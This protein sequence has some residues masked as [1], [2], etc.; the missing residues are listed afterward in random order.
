MAEEVVVDNTAAKVQDTPN[1]AIEAQAKRMGWKPDFPGEGKLSA[2]DFVKKHDETPA[3]LKAELNRA[4]ARIAA[5]E[6]ESRE[7]VKAAKEFQK[8]AEANAQ[9]EW[10][11]KY[12]TL[13]AAQAK[14]VREGDEEAFSAAASDIDTH[15][16]A[17]PT[18]KADAP[19]SQVI[20]PIVTTWKS[21]NPWFG[22][23]KR[24]TALA[25]A[26]GD[27]AFASGERNE[28]K[29]VEIMREAVEERFPDEFDEKPERK[30]GNPQRG[31]RSSGATKT[32]AKTYDNL[33]SESKAA[34]DRLVK[35]KMVK[36]REQY[37]EMYDWRKQDA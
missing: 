37:C 29:L 11:A 28:A 15:R 24:M 30:P 35:L 22:T 2:E 23:N 3:I 32:V 9:R 16:E 20:S 31:G 4:N 33:P 26:A 12:D 25:M 10:K 6:A 7:T 8:L 36:N 1:P 19:A 14:A 13:I 21:E 17:K 18:P 27:E 5:V 34:C